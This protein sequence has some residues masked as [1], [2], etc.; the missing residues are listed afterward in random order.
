MAF[1]VLYYVIE[2]RGH[3]RMDG[4]QADLR[5]GSLAVV[6]ASAVRAISAAGP[7]RVLTIQM[8]R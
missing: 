6:P 3:L 4:E 1:P 7:M 5:D 8:I 2:G